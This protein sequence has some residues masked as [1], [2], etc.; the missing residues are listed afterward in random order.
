VSGKKKAAFG[1][2]APFYHFHRRKNMLLVLFSTGS[3][4][5]SSLQ[6]LFPFHYVPVIIKMMERSECLNR[7][8]FIHLRGDAS[9]IS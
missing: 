7:R 3:R 8:H 9:C 6:I 1:I 2:A 5:F 4:P